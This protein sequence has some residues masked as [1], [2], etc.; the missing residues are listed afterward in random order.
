MIK[1]EERKRYGLVGIL[2]SLRLRVLA[3]EMLHIG[4]AWIFIG[5]PLQVCATQLLPH[6][7]LKIAQFIR[8]LHKTRLG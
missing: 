7:F 3:D 6:L 8:L 1:S 2:E 5:A 4:C